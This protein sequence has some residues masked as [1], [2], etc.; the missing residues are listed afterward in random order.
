MK[1][2]KK[3]LIIMYTTPPYDFVMGI[4]L[5]ISYYW[6]VENTSRCWTMPWLR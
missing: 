1:A 2:V 4:K 5:L 3:I 6:M